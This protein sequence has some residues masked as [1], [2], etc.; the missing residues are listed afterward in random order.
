MT[1]QP[2]RSTHGLILYSL[3]AISVLVIAGCQG[4]APV[5]QE[6]HLP[7]EFGYIRMNP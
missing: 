7:G 6:L 4:P 2:I 5:R 3:I 1:V